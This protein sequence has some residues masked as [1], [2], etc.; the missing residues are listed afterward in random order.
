MPL[1]LAELR[2]GSPAAEIRILIA[3]GTHRAMREEEMRA[4]FGEDLVARETILNHC[5]DDTQHMVFKGTLPSGGELWL[6]SLVDWAD[7]VIAEGFVE[8]H[9]FAGFSGGPKSVLP[10][11]AG[12]PSVLF[13][14]NAALIRHPLA[15]QGS[16]AGNPLRPDFL[17]AAKVARLSFI[18]NV[19]LDSEK[20]IVAAYAGDL[21][22]AHGAAAADC[23][24]RTS[25]PHARADIAITSGGGYP[26]DQNVYQTVKGMTTAQACVKKGGVIILCAALGDGAGGNGFLRFMK[27]APGPLQLLNAIEQTPPEDTKEDQWQ[28]Q[29]LARVMLHATVIFVTGAENQ[30]LVEEIGFRWAAN[31]D[32]ALEAAYGIVGQEAS[33]VVIPDGPGVIVGE[34]APNF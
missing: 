9:F 20:R 12:R 34:D 4:R 15:R 31:T 24:A 25:V 30:K 26:L 13:N 29:I 3:T 1:L 7:L 33:V 11:I 32:A 19:L 2:K 18:L 10:G 5:C 22:A 27:E 14:H 23:L 17:H 8:P 16:L 21:E 28:A 6:N